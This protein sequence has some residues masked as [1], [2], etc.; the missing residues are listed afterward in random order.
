MK[1]ERP[2]NL[3]LLKFKFPVMAI[4]SLLHRISGVLIFLFVPFMLYI[5][6]ES[7]ISQG[8]FETLQD[9]LHHPFAKLM[10]W[11]MLSAVLFHLV[12]GI[13]HLTMDLGFAE[14]R[15]AGRITAW[16]VI[17]IAVILIVLTGVWL[18]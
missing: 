8:H 13:R 7:L 4:V 5:L 2:V 1:T 16:G 15:T 11:I 9:C 12:A 10:I 6:H 17:S 3:N 18:W 14:S